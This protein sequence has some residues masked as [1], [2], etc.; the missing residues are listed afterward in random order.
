M[1]LRHIGIFPTASSSVVRIGW[2]LCLWHAVLSDTITKIDYTLVIW[3]WLMELAY[4]RQKRLIFD[5]FQLLS[6]I[7]NEEK[8]WVT[9]VLS[10]LQTL[11][12]SVII[13]MAIDCS[14]QCKNVTTKNTASIPSCI[15]CMNSVLYSVIW[16]SPFSIV[17]RLWAWWAGFNS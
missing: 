9:K 6:V 15:S 4:P 12:I 3:W 10:Y 8:K 17:T 13:N 1:F 16:N 2:Q 11:Y 14:Q 7:F 5:K